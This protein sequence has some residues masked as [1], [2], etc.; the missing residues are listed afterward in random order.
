MFLS[1]KVINNPERVE[2]HFGVIRSM[3]EEFEE[4]FLVHGKETFGFGLV[5]E[6]AFV[7]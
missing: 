5:K 2:D 1:L 7:A 3:F 4:E 6:S